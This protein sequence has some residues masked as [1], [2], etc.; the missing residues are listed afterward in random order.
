MES[1]KME[2]DEDSIKRIFCRAGEGG[3]SF[4]FDAG[5]LNKNGVAVNQSADEPFE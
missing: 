2:R 3:V 4:P 5:M 1:E